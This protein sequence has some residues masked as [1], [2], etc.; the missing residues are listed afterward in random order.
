MKMQVIGLTMKY[1]LGIKAMPV[2]SE[3]TS[4]KKVEVEAPVATAAS[5][6]SPD[7]KVSVEVEEPRNYGHAF[8][9]QGASTADV[10]PLHRPT[11]RTLKKGE[12]TKVDGGLANL[13]EALGPTLDII[14]EAVEEGVQ[15]EEAIRDAGLVIPEEATA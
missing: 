15:R 12:W 8:V 13:R 3:E 9:D 14:Q 1:F 10:I 11:H 4:F 7:I 6:A 5:S 2:R